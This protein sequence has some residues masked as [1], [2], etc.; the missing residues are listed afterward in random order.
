MEQDIIRIQKMLARAEK[1]QAKAGE[2]LADLHDLMYKLAQQHEAD[3]GI[4]VQSVIPKNPNPDL[5]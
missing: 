2:A 1:K 4:S 5:D 3:L